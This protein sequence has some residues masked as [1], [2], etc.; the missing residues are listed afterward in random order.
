MIYAAFCLSAAFLMVTAVK[1]FS[2]FMGNT[3][4]FSLLEM[5]VF[6]PLFVAAAI[7]I[8]ITEPKVVR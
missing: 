7:A 5:I 4:E 8:R 6:A 1:L 2:S 3:E